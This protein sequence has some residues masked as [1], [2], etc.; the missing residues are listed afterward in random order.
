MTYNN[1]PLTESF[2]RSENG[3]NLCLHV[4]KH[5]N[6]LKIPYPNLLKLWK[7]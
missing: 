1:W 4:Y 5:E 3:R 6:I 7:Y 2:G